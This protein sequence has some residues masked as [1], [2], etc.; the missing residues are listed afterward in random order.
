VAPARSRH[1]PSGRLPMTLFPS[2]ITMA[3]RCTAASSAA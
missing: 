3:Q 2:T 1:Q